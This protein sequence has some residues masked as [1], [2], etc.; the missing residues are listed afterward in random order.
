MKISVAMCTYNGEFFLQDQLNSIRSQIRLP[1]ELIVVDDCSTDTTINILNQFVNR[2]LFPIFVYQNDKNLGA[3][4][5]FEKAINLCSG[6]IIV[7]SDQDDVWMPDKL[8]EIERVFKENSDIGYVFSNAEIVDKKMRSL[9]YTL[10]E[11]VGFTSR[12][13]HQ[14]Q[15][16]NQVKIL[17]SHNVV[18]GDTMAFRSYF[19]NLIIPIPDLWIH[20]YW[21]AFILSSISKGFPINKQLI[22]YRQHP[23]QHIGVRLYTDPPTTMERYVTL[24]NRIDEFKKI[25]DFWSESLARLT[26]VSVAY[27]K[28]EDFEKAISGSKNIIH[29]FKKRIKI[30]RSKQYSNIAIILIELLNGRYHRF[31]NGFKSVIADLLVL[32]HPKNN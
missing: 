9:G 17:L 19:R 16:G 8:A 22:K 20:D 27:L 13:F 6:D 14:Y 5:N 29:H 10:W 2:H 21:I 23:N 32:F 1:D 7:L 25:V 24:N 18:T 15:K 26:E 4:K 3:T 30:H 12:Q 31:S 11:A 28:Q